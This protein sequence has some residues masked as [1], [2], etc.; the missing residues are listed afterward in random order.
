MKFERI[1]NLREDSDLLQKD[2][3][4]MLGISQQYYSEYE[5]GNKT[6]PVS[7]LMELAEYYDVSLDYLVGLTDEKE[8]YTK[9]K[10]ARMLR[11]KVNK[12]SKKIS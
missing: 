7:Q 3:A 5:Q 2:V 11:N 10:A 9:S 8:P 1:K 6:M 4:K 12:N